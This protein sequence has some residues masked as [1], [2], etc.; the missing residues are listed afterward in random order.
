VAC[1]Q[2]KCVRESLCLMK[3][4]C[5]GHMDFSQICEKFFISIIY[6]K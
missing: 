4:P 2:T 3:I 6:D 5:S 1:V